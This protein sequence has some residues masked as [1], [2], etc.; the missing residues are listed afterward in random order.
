M[1]TSTDYIPIDSIEN[2]IYNYKKDCKRL[3]DR[4]AEK[5]TI[6][7]KSEND[8]A[9]LFERTFYNIPRKGQLSQRWNFTFHGDAC[10]F[11]NKKHKQSI[12]V[13]LENF[14]KSEHVDP[15]FLFEYMKS[16]HN[17][18]SICENMDWITF[19]SYLKTHGF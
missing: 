4:L 2:A 10:H 14:Y 8:Y 19:K 9:F 7:K 11:Y 15:W 18:K 3:V 1:N 5:Y 12:E 16:T 6:I 17:F 13:S